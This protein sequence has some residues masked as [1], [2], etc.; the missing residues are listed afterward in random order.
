M[1]HCTIYARFSPRPDALTSTSLEGQIA[2]CRAYAER[3]DWKVRSEH[4]DAGVSGSEKKRNGL[5]AAL[6]ALRRG[7]ILLVSAMDR[8]W[9]DLE[10]QFYIMGRIRNIG[11]TAESVSGETVRFDTPLAR[12]ISGFLGVAYQLQREA[13]A[14]RTSTMMRTAQRNGAVMSRQSPYGF[15]IQL[16]DGTLV[17][18]G[19]GHNRKVLGSGYI[20]RLI[21]DPKEQAVLDIIRKLL[22]RGMR[23]I[24]IA[25]ELNRRGIP[26][27]H[28]GKW[29][30]NCVRPIMHRIEEGSQPVVT[31]I[32]P[33][34]ESEFPEISDSIQE[35]EPRPPEPHDAEAPAPEHDA[36]SAP[37]PIEHTL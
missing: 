11:A 8:L 1:Q 18:D 36:S 13:G 37:E 5:E 29:N 15:W 22:A 25:G 14:E 12:A 2:I 35:S 3:R 32:A 10:V 20:K 17:K 34:D 7:D 6:T 30:Y 27:R 4:S 16:P 19:A 23:D 24:R 31:D 9:R 21:A 28:G 33:S 26:A